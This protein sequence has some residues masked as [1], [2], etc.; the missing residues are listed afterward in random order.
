MI[1]EERKGG[2]GRWRRRRNKKVKL[3]REEKQPS[4]MKVSPFESI[5]IE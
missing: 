1:N 4:G 5:K 3:E 2:R